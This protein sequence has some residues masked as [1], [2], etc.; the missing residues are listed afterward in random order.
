MSGTGTYVAQSSSPGKVCFKDVA[1]KSFKLK[2]SKVNVAC[3]SC[4][5]GAL[6]IPGIK[7]LICLGINK[8]VNNNHKIITSKAESRIK[9]VLAES[10]PG[11]FPRCP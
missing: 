11:Y 8:E 2:T 5:E 7:E 6:N 9:A 3:G 4:K 10:L 1:L